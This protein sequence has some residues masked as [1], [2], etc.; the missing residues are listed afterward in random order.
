VPLVCVSVK[1]FS[2]PMFYLAFLMSCMFR[3][4]N[5]ASATFVFVLIELPCRMPQL[6]C[7][8]LRKCIC[9]LW[10]LV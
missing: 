2:Y 3:M 5:V 8:S 10:I 6:R 4:F 1:E 9:C 7:V